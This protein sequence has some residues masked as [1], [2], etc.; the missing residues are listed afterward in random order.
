M[1][2]LQKTQEGLQKVLLLQ[3]AKQREVNS[4]RSKQYTTKG[5]FQF[6]IADSDKKAM[7]LPFGISDVTERHK[8]WTEPGKKCICEHENHYGIRIQGNRC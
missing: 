7:I 4:I 1:D 6:A 3:Q 8:N 2:A 5:R